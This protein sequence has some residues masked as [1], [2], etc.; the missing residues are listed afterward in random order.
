MLGI[1][2]AFK[3]V[4]IKYMPKKKAVSSS[5]STSN[6]MN[7]KHHLI[8]SAVGGGVAFILTGIAILGGI[9]FAAVW[10]GNAINH[11][12]HKKS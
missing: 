9:V 5:S 2:S 12:L 6:L 3:I 7:F 1:D 11:H 4:H 10:V 8:P